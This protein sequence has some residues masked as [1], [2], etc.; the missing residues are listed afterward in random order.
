MTKELEVVLAGR[1]RIHIAHELGPPKINV[2]AVDIRQATILTF[3]GVSFLGHS[4]IFFK[5]RIS[6]SFILSIFSDCLAVKRHIELFIRLP[7]LLNH[8][9]LN[10]CL[11]LTN[12]F[13][14]SF[15]GVDAGHRFDNGPQASKNGNL[16][17]KQAV[18]LFGGDRSFPMR[19]QPQI[20]C[21]HD[22]IQYLPF[23][24]RSKP[25]QVS[26]DPSKKDS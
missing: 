4:V 23:F 15:P 24:D 8:Q 18:T 14:E 6:L 11:K 19:S 7:F 1:I 5:P 3:F 25:G 9:E 17:F 26:F 21:S 22:L 12:F 20:C 16:G 13:Y 2:L 10:Q